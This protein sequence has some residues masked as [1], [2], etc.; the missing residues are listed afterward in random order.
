MLWR[1]GSVTSNRVLSARVMY[2]HPGKPGHWFIELLISASELES[3]RKLLATVSASAITCTAAAAA[4]ASTQ[5]ASVAAVA[6]PEAAVVSA[7]SYRAQ[8]IAHVPLVS[9]SSILGSLLPRVE[10]LELRVSNLSSWARETA[11]EKR[12]TALSEHVKQLAQGS[13]A[14]A[15]T[16]AAPSAILPKT[17]SDS[18]IDGHESEHDSQ[19]P[20]AHQSRSARCTK[21]NRH[22]TRNSRYRS[23]AKRSS[24]NVHSGSELCVTPNLLRDAAASDSGASSSLLAEAL[25]HGKRPKLAHEHPLLHQISDT[26]L[27]GVPI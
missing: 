7:P 22:A 14:I 3:S 20:P 2:P 4:T 10:R 21:L 26:A 24:E 13:G 1:P 18:D 5:F 19:S 17:E 23:S 16:A 9:E 12:V 11:M 8:A 15:T 27:P 25:P 6:S